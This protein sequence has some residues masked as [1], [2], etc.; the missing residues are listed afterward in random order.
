[1]RAI[2]V[3]LSC[4]VFLVGCEAL[5]LNNSKDIRTKRIEAPLRRFEMMQLGAGDVAFDTKTGQLCRTWDWQTTGKG[6]APDP[7]T[8]LVPQRR[9]GEFTPTCITLYKNYP[10]VELE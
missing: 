3:A 1:M 7:N 6:P 2:V 8:G 4:M 5:N 10:P 9:L